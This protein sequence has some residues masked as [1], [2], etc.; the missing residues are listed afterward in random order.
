MPTI[1]ELNITTGETSERQISEQE[2]ENWAGSVPSQEQLIFSIVSAVQSHMDKAAQSLG[3]D[4]I[5]TAVTYAEEP[6]VAKFQ[7]EGRALRAWR[8]LVWDKCYGE[9][10]KVQASIRSMPTPAEAVSELPV[11][12]AP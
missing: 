11:F 1:K 3:Y 8:S 5:K 6:A 9:L 4:D 10:A 12:V 2:L 7:A